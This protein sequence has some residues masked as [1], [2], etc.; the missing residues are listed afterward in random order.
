MWFPRPPRLLSQP[1]VESYSPAA[2]DVTPSLTWLGTAGF[3]LRAPGR[4]V[5][6]D[7]YVTRHPM[8]HTL[9]Q[10]LVPDEGLS[11]RWVPFADDVFVGHAH[12]DHVLDAPSICLRTGAR[13]LGSA[14]VC[15]VGR[16]AGVPAAQLVEVRG[17]DRVECGVDVSVTALRSAHGRVYGVVPLP[18]EVADDLRWPARYGDLRCGE[19][20]NWHVEVRGA[21]RLSIVHI[22]SA[23]FFADELRGVSADVVCLCAVGRNFRRRY[24]EEVVELTGAR[25]VIP[26][27][28]DWLFDPVDAA[29]RE[30]PGVDLRGFLREIAAT[31]ATPV[32][33]PPLRT[34]AP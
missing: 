17:G 8:L 29:P 2:P 16:A 30:L 1:P 5:V 10:P 24:V 32:L 22:D 19:V 14:S 34:W 13:M 6:L 23:E 11:R 25:W 7:P 12:F 9:T 33:L 31:G 28:W 26:C 3:T 15:R 21:R 20:F 27:H 18:G 4:T